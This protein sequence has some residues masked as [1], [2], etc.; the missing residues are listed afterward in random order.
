MVDEGK[1][2]LCLAS[3]QLPLLKN[4]KL[5]RSQPRGNEVAHCVSSEMGSQQRLD[6]RALTTFPGTP[7]RSVILGVLLSTL[8]PPLSA[9]P[10][11]CF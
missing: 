9:P 3:T 2:A 8:S 10:V 5:I 11:H 6:G 4:G 1:D 7:P